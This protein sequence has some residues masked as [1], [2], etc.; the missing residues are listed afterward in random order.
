MSMSDPIADLLSR[1]RNAAAA[2]H[3]NLKSPSSKLK[4][5]L[6]KV[7]KAEGYIKEFASADTK[8]GQKEVTVEL[9]Y[10]DGRPVFTEISRV[11]KPGRRVYSS[12]KDLPRVHG[13]LGIYV[14]STPKGVLSDQQCRD[15]NVGGEILCKVF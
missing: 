7:L 14:L 3:A 9:K 5:A 4:E 8:V 10:L 1:I 13:G 12:A 15:Q 6:L 2:R 11:S